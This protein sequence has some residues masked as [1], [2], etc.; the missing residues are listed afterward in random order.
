MSDAS[1]R[2]RIWNA[3]NAFY[4][5][6]RQPHSVIQL[7]RSP[8][9]SN[10]RRAFFEDVLNLGVKNKIAIRNNPLATNI[11]AQPIATSSR[12]GQL[13]ASSRSGSD[14][15]RRSAQAPSGNRYFR[16]NFT[17]N[18]KIVRAMLEVG[19]DDD[20]VIYING[21]EIGRTGTGKVVALT[22]RL[23]CLTKNVTRFGGTRRGL[24]RA[25]PLHLPA[26]RRPAR[27]SAPTRTGNQH[28]R[29]PNW[30][31]LEFDD[32][33]C[34]PQRCWWT[35]KPAV[36]SRATLIQR[37]EQIRTEHKAP[38]FLTSARTP[39]TRCPRGHLPPDATEINF[40]APADPNKDDFDLPR[41][42]PA[43]SASRKA[44]VPPQSACR[45]IPAAGRGRTP[46][47][48]LSA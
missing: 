11:L 25:G 18:K 21:K 12:A 24:R 45:V 3:E 16:T 10:I 40:P 28:C 5:A 15:R 31:T 22:S 2:N 13:P 43:Q 9:P 34:N 35:R 42:Q 37:Q 4:Y 36:P 27:R 30:H 23:I 29:V 39:V 48:D 19:V 17:P 7:P 6:G 14:Q 47:C 20:V 46:T 1:F 26:R 44:G 8:T 33:A 32:Q 38:S 41:Q